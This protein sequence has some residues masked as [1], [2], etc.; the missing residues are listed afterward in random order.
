[1]SQPIINT[2]KRSLVDR[3]AFNYF[4]RMVKGHP[5]EAEDAYHI[6]N[7]NEVKAIHRI[8]TWALAWSAALGI[9]GVLIL[10]L[11][12]FY[13]PGWFPDTVMNLPWLGTT[14]VP[15]I[16]T[17]YGVLLVVIEIYYLTIISLQAVHKMAMVCGFPD[18]A[19]PDYQK[20]LEGLY[21]IGME[22]ESK[23]MAK[24]GINPLA[25]LNK[26]YLMIVVLLHRMKGT[27]TNLL[28]KLILKRLLGRVVLRIWI[29]LIGMPV[30]AFWNAWATNAVI[31]EAKVRIMAP[32]LVIR[33]TNQLHEILKDDAEFK[34]FLYDALQFIAVIKRKFHHNHY[35]LVEKLIK[36]FDIETKE[37]K[38][39]EKDALLDK[40][41]K[42]NPDAREGIAKL[43]LFGMI[44]DGK[45]SLKE[46]R[47]LQELQKLNLITFDWQTLKSWERSFVNGQGLDELLSTKVLQD[48]E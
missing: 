1:M 36:K 23:E 45:L 42:I 20:H 26:L 10:Y 44:I 15:I 34:D 5:K 9:L 14:K 4:I 40:V 37:Q 8:R 33:L 48:I 35:F 12:I 29:N 13:L 22:R 43:L 39:L 32:N 38:A 19:D 47:T 46:K 31:K 17:V 28:I 30:Y 24:Y 25:G 41:R 11:P 2:K 7:D 27:I 21:S 3:L 16:T 6:L 18:P